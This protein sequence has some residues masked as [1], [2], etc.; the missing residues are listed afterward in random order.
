MY[1]FLKYISCWI[2]IFVLLTLSSKCTWDILDKMHHTVNNKH[3][4]PL[5]LSPY[6]W[7]NVIKARWKKYD[8]RIHK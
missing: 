3:Y 1:I 6:H 8:R 5:Y 2:L 4:I 7:S